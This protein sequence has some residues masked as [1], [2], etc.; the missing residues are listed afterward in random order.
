MF[1]KNNTFKTIIRYG[2]VLYLCMAAHLS[3]AQLPPDSLQAYKITLTSSEKTAGSKTPTP[4]LTVIYSADYLRATQNRGD[5]QATTWLIWHE[6]RMLL[7]IDGQQGLPLSYDIQLKTNVY[8]PGEKIDS[9]ATTAIKRSGEWDN[10]NEYNGP[11]IGR[12]SFAADTLTIAGYATSKAVIYYTY[13]PSCTDGLIRK[14]TIWYS[15]ELP[16]FCLPPF[17]CLQKIP[18]AA[19]MICIETTDGAKVCYQAT[20]VILQQ[21]P[22]SF[23]RPSKDIRIF[24]PPKL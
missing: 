5:G 18:G 23:F 22:A 4:S 6:R 19:L 14:T 13:P 17:T 9:T 20:E 7:Q 8:L 15:R 11:G 24:Y 1:T 12:I 16:P 2:I 10:P 3:R 21:L